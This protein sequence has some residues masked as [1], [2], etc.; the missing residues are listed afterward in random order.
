MLFGNEPAPDSPFTETEN[1][2]QLV[3]IF[4]QDRLNADEENGMEAVRL[5]VF[6]QL[7]R[8]DKFYYEGIQQPGDH[9]QTSMIYL[10]DELGNIT[11]YIDTGDES[12]LDDLYAEIEYASC[13]DTY[14]VGLPNKITV[15]S[16][17]GLLRHREADIDCATANLDQVRQYLLNGDAAVT[18]LDYYPNGNL[19]KVTG[20]AN[21]KG[22]RF[23]LNY[24]YD[25]NCFHPC[26]I[27]QRQLWLCLN[28]N[29]TMPK[30]WRGRNNHRSEREPNDLRLRPIWSGRHHHRTV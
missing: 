6:P 18:D 7:T 28:R 5:T 9:K 21:Y 16:A 4:S 1:F 29:P 17:E 20:P 3:E 24:S 13:Q 14:V 2:Y 25:S 8:T 11:T 19:E 27:D 23:A 30:I 26:H 15:N 22:E 12:P 10:Y